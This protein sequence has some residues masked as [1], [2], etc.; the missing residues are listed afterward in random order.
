[1]KNLGERASGCLWRIWED[2]N[3]TGRPS[4]HLCLYVY[5]WEVRR[6]STAPVSSSGGTQAPGVEWSTDCL[7]CSCLGLAAKCSSPVSQWEWTVSQ[8]RMYAYRGN[9]QV[10]FVLFAVVPKNVSE[11]S[12]GDFA[13]KVGW[14]LTGFK[15]CSHSFHLSI[16]PIF[17]SIPIFLLLLPLALPVST[18]TSKT[19]VCKC[20]S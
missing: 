14:L 10:D 3:L 7:P 20:C 5:L 18:V 4:G 6:Q 11:G 16:F 13:L 2:E 1:M 15:F 9:I 17:P 12:G 19:V 8:G